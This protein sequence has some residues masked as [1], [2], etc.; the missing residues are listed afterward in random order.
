MPKTT[1]VNPEVL[2]K[3]LLKAHCSL[4]DGDGDLFWQEFPERID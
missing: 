3:R 2:S 1:L 4:P